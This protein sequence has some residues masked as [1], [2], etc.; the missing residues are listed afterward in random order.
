MLAFVAFPPGGNRAFI[1][2]IGMRFMSLLGP[3]DK[4]RKVFSS[5]QVNQASTTCPANYRFT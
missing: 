4:R 2:C 5:P 1:D 3:S